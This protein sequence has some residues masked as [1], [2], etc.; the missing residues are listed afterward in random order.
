MTMTPEAAKT[1]PAADGTEGQ[2]LAR[3]KQLT[4]VVAPTTM[5]TTLLFY[6]GY[7]GTRSRFEYFGVYLDMTDL[8]NQ[9]LLLYGLEVIYVPAALG[10]AA[11]LAVIVIHAGVRWL[12]DVRRS[13]TV[14]LAI[15]LG[16]VLLGILLIGR[17]LVGILVSRVYDTEFP[18]TTPLA[19][20][21]GPA[22]AA[23]GI[24]ICTRRARARVDETGERT[25]SA[26]VTWYDGAAMKGLRRSGQVCAAGLV[27]AGLF[28][29]VHEFAW[30]FGADRA[31]DDA[32]K[33][34]EQPEVVL[35]TGERLTDLPAKVTES[36]LSPTQ[37]AAFRYRYRGLRLLVASGGRLF[38]VP[39]RWTEQ[40]RTLVVPYNGEV[41]IQLIPTQ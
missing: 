14:A 35:D 38:L 30:A 29:A 22:A 8:S 6:F 17:A 4:S 5:I 19:L 27:V 32:V 23:Y 36:S 18:G 31:Y 9:Q 24:W 40:G 15:G 21:I 34:P 39:Q 25:R 28:W 10:F 2:M 7:V 41:R 3:L 26:F 1:A 13:D 16:A 11:V 20:A 33:L 37:E 12:L